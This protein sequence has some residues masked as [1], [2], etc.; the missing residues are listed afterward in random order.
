MSNN[1]MIIIGILVAVFVFFKMARKSPESQQEVATETSTA[2]ASPA[3][4]DEL[5]AV[6]SAAIAANDDEV[7]AVIAAAL[8]ACGYGAGQIASI[9]AIPSRNWAYDA[10]YT[11]VHT[12]D[13][14]F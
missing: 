3:G 10:R 7:I 1:T 11:A 4:D 14:M 2:T 8:A 9:T 6:I 13:Q 12:R 5:I